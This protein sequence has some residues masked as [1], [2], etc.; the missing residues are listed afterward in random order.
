MNEYDIRVDDAIIGQHGIRWNS[1]GGIDGTITVGETGIVQGYDFGEAIIV[2][3]APDNSSGRFSLFNAGEISSATDRTVYLGNQ[4]RANVENT[5]LI[6]SG[7]GNAVQFDL[8]I[9]AK[10]TNTG[11]IATSSSI[12][13]AILCNKDP[14]PGLLG[15]GPI[16]LVWRA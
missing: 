15:S 16:D 14:D 3:P 7:A 1:Q 12:S 9:N 8:T 10:V 2:Y 11:T 6:Q 13:P 4:F 5:G